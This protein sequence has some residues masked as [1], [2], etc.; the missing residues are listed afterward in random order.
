MTKAQHLQKIQKLLPHAGPL[1][2]S[3]TPNSYFMPAHVGR[4]FKMV[5]N[6]VWYED[7]VTSSI[8]QPPFVE[9]RALLSLTVND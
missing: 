6:N 4:L 7:R 1:L 9:P 5:S 8:S 2:R 3:V